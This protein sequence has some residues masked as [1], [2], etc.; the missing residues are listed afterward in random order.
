MNSKT[1]TTTSRGC[2][3]TAPQL[4]LRSPRDFSLRARRLRSC[5]CSRSFASRLRCPRR[6]LSFHCSRRPGPTRRLRSARRSA[7]ALRR[8]PYPSHPRQD[9]IVIGTPRQADQRNVRLRQERVVVRE[10]LHRIGDL[11]SCARRLALLDGG[12]AVGQHVA[13]SAARASQRGGRELRVPRGRKPVPPGEPSRASAASRS[14]SPPSGGSDGYRYPPAK[15]GPLGLL[16][17]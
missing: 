2:G 17:T 12:I 4:G 14:A 8:A 9:V 3:D 5:H 15:V 10:S 11:A 7:T 16:V 1:S 13:Q 6:L